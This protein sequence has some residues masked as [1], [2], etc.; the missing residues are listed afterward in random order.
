LGFPGRVHGVDGWRLRSLRSPK[1][2]GRVLRVLRLRN[3]LGGEIGVYEAVC[4]FMA[5]EGGS[6]VSPTYR[7]RGVLRRIRILR[8]RGVVRRVAAHHL[9]D[10]L[11]R[12]HHVGLQRWSHHAVLFNVVKL[13]REQA[14]ALEMGE[15]GEGGAGVV[16]A[17]E[18]KQG[19]GGGA[20]GGGGAPTH[21]TKEKAHAR[22]TR[23]RVVL[24]AV[25]RGQRLPVGA[26]HARVDRHARKEGHDAWRNKAGHGVVPPRG[27]SHV[28]RGAAGAPKCVAKGLQAARLRAAVTAGAVPSGW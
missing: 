3:R 24:Y 16:W 20:A 18:R 9:L 4:G 7:R 21:A 13:L 8:G 17:G 1:L 23:I 19:E 6:C 25:A 26:P 15:G 2:G 27:D 22:Q 10:R 12:H 5:R 14:G 11:L 28:T